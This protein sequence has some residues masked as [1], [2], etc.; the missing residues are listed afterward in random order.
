MGVGRR[1]P[2]T[3]VGLVLVVT[4]CGGASDK[5]A[6]DSLRRSRSSVL[7]DM[8]QLRAQRLPNL[9]PINYLF[10]DYR[11]CT[12]DN[13]L[14]YVSGTSWTSLKR[15]YNNPA[16]LTDVA[17]FLSKNGWSVAPG[18][19]A[20]RRVIS[21]GPIRIE[22]VGLKGKPS[23]D[24]NGFSPCFQVGTA[25]RGFLRSSGDEFSR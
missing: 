3:A 22:V 12:A 10:G 19:D 7:A 8:R 24:A 9:E 5:A 14:R 13:A 16:L 6:S 23:I 11:P 2:V 18:S 15:D 25:S 17:L 4:A 1:A 21:K 20:E